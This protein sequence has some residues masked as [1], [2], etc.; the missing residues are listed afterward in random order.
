MNNGANDAA[1]AA[2]AQDAQNQFFQALV[3]QLRDNRSPQV[4]NVPCEVFEVGGDF[5]AWVKLFEDNIRAV[6]NLGPNDG[7]RLGTLSIKWLPT[8]L[9]VGCTRSVFENL[10]DTVKNN[11]DQLKQALSTAY[12]DESEEINFLSNE[13]AFKRAPGMS[14]RDYKNSLVEKMNKYQS[15]LRGVQ[16]EW[17]RCAIRRFRLGLNNPVLD[18]QI[19][20]S[21][22]SNHTLENAYNIAC[23]FEN[24]IQTISQTSGAKAIT[25]MATMLPM[26]QFSALS[27]ETPQFS[28]F[29]EKTEK[30]FEALETNL[31]KNELDLSEVKTGLLELKESVKEIKDDMTKNKQPT[32]SVF[33]RR[34]LYSMARSPLQN[35]FSRPFYPNQRSQGYR[36]QGVVQGISGGPG[37]ATRQ[38]TPNRNLNY[39]TPV[40]QNS[41]N[42]SGNQTARGDATT[43]PP[44][45]SSL[46]DGNQGPQ[47]FA[48]PH[49]QWGTSDT[50]WGWTDAPWE[51]A[52]QEGYDI[53]PEGFH[54]F[55]EGPTPF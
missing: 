48:N 49:L 26:T 24:T 16:S 1:Q 55:T 27:D 50:G 37:Y 11:W 33:Q 39:S 45:V 9:A 17:H 14:L 19:L 43:T 18:A 22:G 15:S 41:R 52:L 8:K 40:A 34:P 20:M 13:G 4:R 36:P 53:Y 7:A 25:T 35:P 29:G 6:H 54:A 28:A 46:E 30:R 10:D 42:I 12:K 44:T 23:T 2:A 47:S 31:K 51:E 38:P 32:P 3:D 21:L 5:E